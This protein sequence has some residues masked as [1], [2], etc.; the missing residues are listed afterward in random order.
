M[1]Q[2]HQKETIGGGEALEDSYITWEVK[3][4]PVC[5]RLTLEFYSAQVISDG[6]LERI[7]MEGIKNLMF[8]ISDGEE[9]LK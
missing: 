4:C 2:M 3:V 1:V 5:G 6:M 7:K 9:A 8:K